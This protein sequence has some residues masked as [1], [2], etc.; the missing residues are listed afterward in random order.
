MIT[1]DEYM[2]M[3]KISITTLSYKFIKFFPFRW[4]KVNNVLYNV[5]YINYKNRSD[6][7]DIYTY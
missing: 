5:F 7:T 4:W 6:T 1:V 2:L 3:R